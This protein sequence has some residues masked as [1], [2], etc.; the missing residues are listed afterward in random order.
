MLLAVWMTK[1]AHMCLNLCMGGADYRG[2]LQLGVGGA[3]PLLG[4]MKACCGS[5]FGDVK[6]MRLWSC[7]PSKAFLCDADGI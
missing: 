7:Q 1:V 2:P 6:G 4:A 5:S 3:L